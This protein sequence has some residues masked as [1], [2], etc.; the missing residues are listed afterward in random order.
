MLLN[1]VINSIWYIFTII[2]VLYKFTSFFTTAWGFIKFTG[3]LYYGIKTISN[4]V[5]TYIKT[6]IVGN[7]DQNT[8]ENQQLN[9]QEY[10]STNYGS[11]NTNDAYNNRGIGITGSIAGIYNRFF[12]GYKQFDKTQ[13]DSVVPLETISVY[14]SKITDTLYES[15]SCEN[16]KENNLL[17]NSSDSQLLSPNLPNLKLHELHDYY[18]YRSEIQLDS[19][20]E[21]IEKRGKS[22]H[23]NKLDIQSDVNSKLFKSIYPEGINNKHPELHKE[24]DSELLLQSHFINETLMKKNNTNTFSKTLINKQNINLPFAQQQN[25]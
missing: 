7:A 23:D 6:H 12:N 2:F 15:K 4:N 8:N 24:S 17:R 19:H 3:K 5:F 14:E 9:N 13:N 22:N 25:N 1:S 16:K 18:D 10:S 11:T 21:K 20:D